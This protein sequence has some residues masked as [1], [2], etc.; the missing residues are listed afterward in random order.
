MTI[1]ASEL[2]ED[3]MTQSFENG[4][5]KYK[6]IPDDNTTTAI[7]LYYP[8][9]YPTTQYVVYFWAGTTLYKGIT[10]ASN[11]SDLVNMTVDN[12]KLIVTDPTLDSSCTISAYE[13][14]EM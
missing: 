3:L 10:D 12:G 5:F 11:V 4:K 9:D 2:G 7:A 8:L 14:Y 6:L 1:V 13:F